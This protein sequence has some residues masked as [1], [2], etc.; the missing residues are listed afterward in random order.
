MKNSEI[1]K[2]AIAAPLIAAPLSI[3]TWTY[4]LPHVHIAVVQWIQILQSSRSRKNLFPKA[5]AF[6]IGW[7][8]LLMATCRIPDDHMVAC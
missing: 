4:F 1:F 3:K 8:R 7:Q 6:D 5:Q 2:A